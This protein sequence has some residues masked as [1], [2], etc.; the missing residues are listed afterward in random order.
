MDLFG[1][2]ILNNYMGTVVFPFF[3]NKNKIQIIKK[4]PSWGR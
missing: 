4:C 1:Q 2:N 3:I